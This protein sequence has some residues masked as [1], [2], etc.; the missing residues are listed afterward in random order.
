MGRDL[1][2]FGL[3]IGGFASFPFCDIL[4]SLAIAI[5]CCIKCVD[6][7]GFSDKRYDSRVD[8]VDIPRFKEYIRVFD[9]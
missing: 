5:Y 6:V 1:G 9:L 4:N 7:A 2:T 8:C 3:G